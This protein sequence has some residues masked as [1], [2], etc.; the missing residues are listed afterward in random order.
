MGTKKTEK[1]KA[2][3]TVD[4]CF[5]A[6]RSGGRCKQTRGVED[7]SVDDGGAV[8][9]VALCGQ[10]RKK[11]VGSWKVQAPKDLP[12]FDGA[13][14]RPRGGAPASKFTLSKRP[15]SF[16]GVDVETEEDLDAVVEGALEASRGEDVAKVAA[17]DK[18]GETLSRTA[19]SVSPGDSDEDLVARA[20][21][22]PFF[23]GLGRV[24]QRSRFPSCEASRGD[25]HQ[26]GR[27]AGLKRLLDEED[28][29]VADLC[30]VHL[31]RLMG[32]NGT[33]KTVLLLVDG[34]RLAPKAKGF[35]VLEPKRSA[36]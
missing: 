28:A 34:R 17:E 18:R 6:T 26:C 14:V 27:L 12:L 35:E 2:P 9:L 30:P 4:R 8:L 32:R 33:P 31:G 22:D 1:N 5:A 29:K 16:D 3:K 24:S 25:G 13:V 36:S 20:A 7:V 15:T 23:R 10:H 19:G 21:I 11:L